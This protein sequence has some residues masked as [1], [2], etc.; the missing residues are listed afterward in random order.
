MKYTKAVVEKLV[1]VYGSDCGDN[2]ASAHAHT[3]NVDAATV[4]WKMYHAWWTQRHRAKHN[5]PAN[6]R[7]TTAEIND[8]RMSTEDFV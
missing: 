5:L 4:M 2:G 3:H 8:L 6:F 7:C 1:D